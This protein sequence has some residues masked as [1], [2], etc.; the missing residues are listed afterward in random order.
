MAERVGSRVAFDDE[1]VAVT[2]YYEDTTGH[3]TR[4]VS[5]NDGEA[6]QV[7]FTISS[8]NRAWTGTRT[9]Q[10][11]TV[12]YSVPAGLANRID[13]NTGDVAIDAAH[14]A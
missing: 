9:I 11:G 2:V 4:I 10:A 13:F 1:A 5:E 14:E 7:T 6:T 8:A 3:P 12:D